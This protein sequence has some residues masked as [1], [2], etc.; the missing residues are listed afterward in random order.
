MEIDSNDKIFMQY[1]W[2][3]WASKT[4]F[5]IVGFFIDQQWS[6]MFET[7]SLVVEITSERKV[8]F[9]RNKSDTFIRFSANELF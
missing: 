4:N 5:L 8:V 7:E 9:S 1:K 6:D 2:F 3:F